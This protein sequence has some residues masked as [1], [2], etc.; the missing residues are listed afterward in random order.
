MQAFF[1]LGLLWPAPAYSNQ[2][3]KISLSMK[4]QSVVIIYLS[5]LSI[6]TWILWRFVGMSKTDALGLSDSPYYYGTLYLM[7]VLSLVYVHYYVTSSRLLNIII[8]PILFKLATIIRHEPT[9]ALIMYL[10]RKKH[11]DIWWDFEYLYLDLV[12]VN[13]CL[14]LSLGI[15]RKLMPEKL[16]S[17]SGAEILDNA[18]VKQQPVVIA[19]LLL[20]AIWLWILLSYI[21]MDEHEFM[22]GGS[23]PYYQCTIWAIYCLALLYARLFVSTYF[24]FNVVVT[25]LLFALACIIRT[26]PT[27]LLIECIVKKSNN[28]TRLEWIYKY[29]F[30]DLAVVNVFLLL[31]FEIVCDRVPV[32]WRP[33]Y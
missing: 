24:L 6:W 32:K 1:V 15:M 31:A 3:Q 2:V 8:T 33:N 18:H 14:L 10:M 26:L 30:L 17:N 19:N 5:L 9:N 11:I 12:T 22:W 4:R 27:D 13:V 16:K 20:L 25:S 23:D 29:R 7:Y 28:R 21:R